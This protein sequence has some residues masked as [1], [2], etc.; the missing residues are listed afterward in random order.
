MSLNTIEWRVVINTRRARKPQTV[1]ELRRVLKYHTAIGDTVIF[2]DWRI[3]R[4]DNYAFGVANLRTRKHA[5]FSDTRN[6]LAL[7]T[8]IMTF[9]EESTPCSH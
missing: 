8:Q 1:R 7:T 5:V 2:N 3:H 4:R 9:I 6:V